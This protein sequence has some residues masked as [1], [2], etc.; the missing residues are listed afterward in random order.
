MAKR[1]LLFVVVN[2]LVMA[3]IT[4]VVTITGVGRYAGPMGLNYGALFMFCLIWGMGGS[5]ISLLI[6]RIVAK[7]LM[8]VKVIDTATTN[9]EER[10]LVDTV[11]R[12]AQQANLPMPEV[13]W[14]ESDEVNAF[15]TGP[16]KSRALVAVS[17][18]L[19][20]RMS[21]EHVEGVLGHEITHVAN[22]DMVT[23]TLIQGIVNAFV[24]FIARIIAFFVSQGVR[25]EWR[26]MTNFIV[27]IVLQIALSILGL[28]VVSWFSRQREFRADAG[29][30]ALAGRN[31]MIGA[32]QA[33]KQTAE[34]VDTDQKSLATLKIAGPAGGISRLFMTHPP[35]DERIEALQRGA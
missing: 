28:M 13:G 30:A 14:Y 20:N 35:L 34:L 15:A 16:S 4:I 31:K 5:V 23:M 6:S 11:H 24:M 12:L 7:M 26:A 9:P 1:I 17:S 8:G 22:G 33:L 10:W 19:M 27:T 29:G 25:E 21:R 18:G 2:I 3:T 32:L